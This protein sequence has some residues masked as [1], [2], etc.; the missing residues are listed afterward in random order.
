MDIKNIHYLFALEEVGNVSV[1]ASRLYISQP[2]LSQ[3]LKKY[4]EYLG[5]PIFIR[6]KEGLKVTGE[7]KTFLNTARQIVQLEQDM[8][9]QLADTSGLMEGTVTFAV[10]S[11]RATNVL[12]LILPQFSE[13]YPKVVVNVKEGRTKELELELQRGEFNLA[14]LVPPLTSPDIPFEEI[15]QEEILLAVP[16][17]FP[18]AERVHRDGEHLPWLNLAELTDEPFLLLDIK[19]RLC[20]LTNEL[21]AQ[22]HF[23]P[24][25]KKIFQN[26]TLNAKLASRGMGITFLPECF[27]DPVYDLDYYAIGQEGVYRS[28]ALGYAPYSYRSHAV[29]AFAEELKQSMIRQQKERRV[30][31][32]NH[33]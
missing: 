30:M 10:S 32:M 25:H 23:R 14:L 33:V 28:L 24:E 13:K 20:D 4:E 17:S 22:H 2:S 1:A 6:T 8:R 31:I 26:V 18:I 3:F 12:P 29:Q 7:G 27:I 19:N 9:N 11:Q 5:Y 16:R 15:I 21:F